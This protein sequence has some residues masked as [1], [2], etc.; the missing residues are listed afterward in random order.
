MW[1]YL[2]LIGLLAYGTFYVLYSS[3]RNALFARFGAPLLGRLTPGEDHAVVFNADSPL[4]TA[5]AHALAQRGFAL[6][7]LQSLGDDAAKQVP[8]E[9][10]V[11]DEV[12]ADVRARYGVAVGLYE[13]SED[14]PSA[15]ETDWLRCHAPLLAVWAPPRGK[16]RASFVE[17]YRQTVLLNALKRHTRDLCQFFRAVVPAMKAHGRGVILTVGNCSARPGCGTPLHSISSGCMGFVEHY[18]ASIATELAEDRVVVRHAVH[19]GICNPL[20]YP[21]SAGYPMPREW[22]EAALNRTVRPYGGAVCV[23]HLAHALKDVVL[24]WTPHVLLAPL[25]GRMRRKERKALFGKKN[26]P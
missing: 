6:L 4:G 3:S 25:L 22:A 7:L 12:A 17:E 18:V 8:G 23:P 19:H 15:T 1:W 16:V 13:A 9:R 24:R 21:P 26:P 20:V 2:P 14:D 10:N 11:L 5:F